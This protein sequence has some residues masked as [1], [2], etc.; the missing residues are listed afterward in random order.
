MYIVI[1]ILIFALVAKQ[2]R[3][4]SNYR[5]TFLPVSKTHTNKCYIFQQC[6]YIVHIYIWLQINSVLSIHYDITEILLKVA[7]STVNQPNSVL[8]VKL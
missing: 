2:V 4:T 3:K 1:K 6:T 5:L 7:L 8:H